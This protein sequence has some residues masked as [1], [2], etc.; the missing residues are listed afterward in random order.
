MCVGGTL[1]KRKYINES[2]IIFIVLKIPLKFCSIMFSRL[3][4][5]PPP[6]YCCN[7]GSFFPTILFSPE[8]NLIW[9]R[10]INLLG[11]K[12][13]HSVSVPFHV[14]SCCKG[15]GRRGHCCNCR[16]LSFRLAASGFSKRQC[17][18]EKH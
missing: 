4:W 10:T 17:S 6:F 7:H 5:I 8:S 11:Q 12:Q 9:K 13:W 18:S 2:T 15:A 1:C 14:S 3:Y 16:L